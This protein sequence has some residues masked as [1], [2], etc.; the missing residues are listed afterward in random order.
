MSLRI[1]ILVLTIAYVFKINAR[2]VLLFQ[3][4]TSFSSE[5]IKKDMLWFTE[6]PHPMGSNHQKEISKDLEDRLKKNGL[7]TEV[8]KFR[9]V[10]P[11]LDA[12]KFGGTQKNAALTKQIWSYNVIATRPG[13][14]KCSVLISGHY[15]TKFFK[16]ISFIGAN[17]GGSSTALLLELSR[18]LEKAHFDKR[19]LGSCSISLVFF[20]GEEAFFPHWDD[21]SELLELQDNTYGS[22]AFVN[23]NLRKKFGHVY[24][25]NKPL[26]LVTVIDMVGHQHQELSITEGSDDVYA[27][28]FIGFAQNIKIGKSQMHIED[29]QDPFLDI[30]APVLHI[31]D[32]TNTKEWHTEKDTPN[33]ISYRNIKNFGDSIVRFLS[34]ESR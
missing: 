9:S 10:V 24:F 14:Q 23:M 27:G 31:I 32:W 15:D 22:R 4:S 6:K 13:S 30:G 19:S 7:K 2:P 28:K 8:Q 29:D 16:N 33:I 21:G 34:Q 25:K 5:N 3:N 20:D 1:M 11:N 18:V 12:E 26:L 17:D